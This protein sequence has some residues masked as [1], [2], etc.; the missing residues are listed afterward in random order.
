MKKNLVFIYSSIWLFSF[1][2]AAQV[3]V[4]TFYDGIQA[5][6]SGPSGVAVDAN[7]NVYVADM[8]GNK[9]RKISPT[10]LVSTVAGSD[11]IG[12]LDGEGTAASFYNPTGLAL[13]AIGN[14]YVADLSNHRIRKISPSGL[15][16]TLAG[17]RFTRKC[18]WTRNRS[19]F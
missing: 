12:S 5:S 13:D 10:G 4:S 14:L 7:G 9:I 2:A 18:R 16:S 8:N 6:F 15:V 17:V 1:N 11:K 3:M 19:Q